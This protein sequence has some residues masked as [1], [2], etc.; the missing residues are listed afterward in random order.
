MNCELTNILR[1]KNY[2]MNYGKDAQE[3]QKAEENMKQVSEVRQE[4]GTSMNITMF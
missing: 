1:G 3:R 2:D 4:K